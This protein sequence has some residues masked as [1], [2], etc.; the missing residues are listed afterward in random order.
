MSNVGPIFALIG[1][2]ESAMRRD[3][4]FISGASLGVAVIAW[5]LWGNPDKNSA[6]NTRTVQSVKPDPGLKL[7]SERSPY[8][9]TER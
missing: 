7:V 8:M 5:G 3:L 9:R 4:F 6:S 2:K 1:E